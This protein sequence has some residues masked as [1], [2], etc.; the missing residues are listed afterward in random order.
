MPGGLRLYR[1]GP[2][3]VPELVERRLFP[4]IIKFMNRAF[5]ISLGLFL[6]GSCKQADRKKVEFPDQFLVVLGVVQ[7]AG[8]PQLGC[9]KECCNAFWQGKESKKHVVSLAL[10]DKTRHEYWLIEATPDIREQ[11]KE[12]E[13]YISGKNYLPSGIFLTHA[14]MGHYSGLLQL[15]R[16]AM[17]AKS[18]PVY[19]Q[20]RMDSFLRGNGP[21]SQLVALKNIELPENYHG[22]AVNLKEASLTIEPILVPHRDEFSETV[23]YRIIGKHKKILF[24]PDIDKWAKWDQPLWEELKMVDQAFIDGTFYQDGELPGRNMSEIPHPFVSETMELLKDL[25]ASEKAKVYF[26]HFNHTNPLGRS[27]SAAKDSVRA[28]GFNVAE[29]RMVIG[30]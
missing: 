27:A 6:L 21:W 19:V 8:Y 4:V 20:P 22:E 24:I 3:A 16:E 7:D 23:G 1:Q 9:E 2:S 28:K 15:G 26:I 25:P 12:M 14:H 29:E 17:A 30:L 10:V 11:M 18:I 13:N 5:V